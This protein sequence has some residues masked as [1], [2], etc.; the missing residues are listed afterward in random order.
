MVMSMSSQYIHLLTVVVTK[1]HHEI[2]KSV[3]LIIFVYKKF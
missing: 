3:Q 1:K 2:A